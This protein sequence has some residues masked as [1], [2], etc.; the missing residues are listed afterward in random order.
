MRE[1]AS[2]LGIFHDPLLM[3]IIIILLQTLWIIV[4]GGESERV[5]ELTPSQIHEQMRN[6]QGEIE[7]LEKRKEELKA[8]IQRLTD[9]LRAL[10]VLKDENKERE[11]KTKQRIHQLTQEIAKLKLIIEEKKEEK[12]RLEREL[13]KANRHARE[14]KV[15]AELDRKIRELKRKLDE[16]QSELKKL[17]DELKKAKKAKEGRKTSE[18]RQRKRRDALESQIAKVKGTINKLENERKKLKEFLTTRRG[19]EPYAPEGAEGKEQIAFEAVNNRVL[20]INEENYRF[21]TYLT[22]HN[23]YIVEK[24]KVVKK[25]SAIGE[26]TNEI[27][28]SNSEFQTKL[29]RLDP[30]KHYIYFIV[31]KDSFEVF[32]KAR[33]IAW[34]MGFKVGWEPL[35]EAIYAG[36]GGTSPP[37]R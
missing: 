18:E 27:T 21:E 30:T 28:E 33:E 3:Y 26:S 37:V 23:N 6:L 16:K 32:Q 4:P 35:E 19:V 9:E 34:K 13:E 31:R 7:L 20:L 5:G 12:E 2:T 14:A 15:V 36:R 10:E 29:S 1:E 11:K 8:E 22:I 24:A 17:E 25:D